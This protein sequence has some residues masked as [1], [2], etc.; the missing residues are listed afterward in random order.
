MRIAI[1][2]GEASGDLLGAGLI[3]ALRA[4]Y[5]DAEFGGMGGPLMQGAGCESL[6]PMEHLSIMGL[7]E[8]LD[9]LPQLFELRARLLAYFVGWKA[10]IFIG[11]DAPDFNL[12]LANKIK[13]AGI[14]TV[15]YVSPSVWAWRQGRIHGIKRSVD[16]ML[17]LLPFE[18]AFYERWQV[19]VAFVG[20]PLADEIALGLEPAPARAQLGLSSDTSG[21]VYAILPGSRGSE[22]SRLGTVFLQAARVLKRKNPAAVFLIPAANA[23]RESQLHYL[24]KAFPDLTADQSV[25]VLQ[26]QARIALQA[27]DGVILASGTASLEA[28]LVGRPMVVAYR[29]AR[30][31]YW[32]MKRLMKSKYI[33]LPNLLA[34]E[35]LVPELIQ[36]EVTPE[37]IAEALLRETEASRAAMLK[38]RFRSLHKQIHCNAS[39]RAAKAIKTE[40]LDKTRKA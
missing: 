17:T 39:E 5:P 9:S 15:H 32:I 28:M 21:P 22:V 13:R 36:D 12:R 33:A 35:A 18:A 14:P 37:R 6:F 8:V 24:L 3:H 26:G 10:D 7:V 38:Q 20:H 1:V 29:L 27:A 4:Q 31:T 11:I 30:P 16:L 23:I 25:R 19:P 2:A 40:I 34:D